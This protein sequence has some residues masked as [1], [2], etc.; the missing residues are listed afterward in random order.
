MSFKTLPTDSFFFFLQLENKYPSATNVISYRTV[1]QYERKELSR[2]E[3]VSYSLFSYSVLFVCFGVAEV[4]PLHC[5][6]VLRNFSMHHILCTFHSQCQDTTSNVY[7]LFI[8]SHTHLIG[9]VFEHLKEGWSF[10]HMYFYPPSYKCFFCSSKESHVSISHCEFFF[11]SSSHT[12]TDACASVHDVS[13]SCIV[14]SAM[15]FAP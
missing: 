4:W 14:M 15:L 5:A 11:F 2:G 8:I 3:R 7:S 12:L 10:L 13:F 9:L 6:F 1:I